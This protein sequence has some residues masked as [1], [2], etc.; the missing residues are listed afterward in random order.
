[1]RS[2]FDR[3]P[4]SCEHVGARR[5]QNLQPGTGNSSFKF[6]GGFHQHKSNSVLS[7][8]CN[9]GIKTIVSL[10]AEN[11]SIVLLAACFGNINSHTDWIWQTH[12]Y[13][14]LQ[15][16]YGVRTT[17]RLS[18]EWLSALIN[19]LLTPWVIVLNNCAKY[20]RSYFNQLPEYKG[21]ES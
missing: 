16:R 19:R 7:W 15:I 21:Y 12:Y 8:H 11:R 6:T 4:M 10:A 5:S 13:P 3:Y 20:N 18:D 14:S 9:D 2:V 1:M 17:V